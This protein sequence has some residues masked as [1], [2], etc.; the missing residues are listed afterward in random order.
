MSPSP[1]PSRRVRQVV[2][3]FERIASPEVS[4]TDLI[5][6]FQKQYQALDEAEQAALFRALLTQVETRR[7]DVLPDL[8]RLLRADDRDLVEWSRL[9]TGLRRHIESPRLRALRRCLNVPGG[10]K[11][12]LDL[13]ADVL[14]AERQGQPDVEPL[15]EE[16]GHLLNS[17]FRHGLL[18]LREITAESSFRQIRFLKEHDLVHPMT[19]LE[20]M[21]QRLGSDRRCFA[22]YHR[23]MPEEPVV[24]IEVA[25]TRSLP[26]SL[27][28]ILGQE[29]GPETR[30]SVPTTA[31]F[32]SIN[33]TQHGLTGLGLGKLLIFRVVEALQ[34]DHSA[35]KSFATLS[36]IPGF[37][38][39]YLRPILEGED[40]PFELERSTIDDFFSE[41]GRQTV[42]AHASE[43]SGEIDDFADALRVTLDEPGWIDKSAVKDAV[44]A[45]LERLAY[46]YLSREKNLHGKPL[47]PVARFHIG[48]GARLR[49]RH[50]HFGA[51]RSPRGLEESLSLM[52]NYVYSSTWPQELGR[53]MQSLLP[54][55][56]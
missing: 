19:S 32:Y 44:R 1:S 13:R 29:T 55:T 33:N 26:A 14:A 18:F 28:E 43:Q 6:R 22:L 31:I 41:G 40:G 3:Q 54:W 39:R 16:L 9:L 34:Q 12:L 30:R 5:E 17:W 47:N 52:V 23:A 2:T 50:I 37:W 25:L 24:F 49:L 46:H 8:Q 35:I 53:T 36:P 7:E 10:L 42:M 38:G 45:P 4:P 51:N 21:G 48:N 11:F 56:R 20:E 15:E 27:D